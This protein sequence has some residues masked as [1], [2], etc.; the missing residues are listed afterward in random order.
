MTRKEKIIE[1]MAK[2]AHIAFPPP[3]KSISDWDNLKDAG[4]S[5]SYRRGRLECAEV[6]LSV[7]TVADLA[8]LAAEHGYK[9]VPDEPNATT[10]KICPSCKKGLF[11]V[12]SCTPDGIMQISCDNS[13]CNYVRDLS[14]DEFNEVMTSAIR[15]LKRDKKEQVE[16]DGNI[17]IYPKP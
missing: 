5:N 7:L 15:T 14:E 1:K 3:L 13:A 17:T 2:A 4:K 16:D 8:A 12:H 9:V 10:I 11:K 6:H